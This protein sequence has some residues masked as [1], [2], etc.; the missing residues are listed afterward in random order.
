MSFLV[1]GEYRSLSYRQAT[2]HAAFKCW[3]PA[4][5]EF[6]RLIPKRLAEAVPGK[7]FPKYS[8][9]EKGALSFLC[10]WDHSGNG[11]GGSDILHNQ[12]GISQRQAVACGD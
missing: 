4:F 10:M 1:I 5:K 9:S 12:H 11:Q 7:D 8:K 3:L 6:T 2:S